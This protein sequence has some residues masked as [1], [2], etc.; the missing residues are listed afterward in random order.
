MKKFISILTQGYSS[1]SR[2]WA[3]LQ[4]ESIDARTNID[5]GFIVCEVHEEDLETTLNQIKEMW[6]DQIKAINVNDSY[7]EATQWRA[8]YWN[9]I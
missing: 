1:S 7:S 4:L 5:N 9:Q 2:L 8:N 3:K 6:G